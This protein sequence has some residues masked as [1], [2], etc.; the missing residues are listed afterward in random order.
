MITVTAPYNQ[1]NAPKGPTQQEGNIYFVEIDCAGV[2][3]YPGGQSAHKKEV[4]FRIASSGAWDASN[5]WSYAGIETKPGGTP[6][7]ARHI[8]VY[9]DGT[10]VF[11]TEPNGDAEAP[12]APSGL[13]ATAKTATSITLGWTASTDNVG[14]KAYDVYLGTTRVGT[15]ATTSYTVTGLTGGTSYAFTVRARDAAGNASP[16]SAP[17]TA[18]TQSSGPDPGPSPGVDSQAPSAPTGLAATAWTAT[19][20]TLGWSA[21]TDNVGVAGYDIYRGDQL[22]TSVPS[23][24]TSYTVTG[25]TASTTYAFTVKA[26]DAAGNRSAPTTISAATQA[27]VV[28]PDTQAPT[29]PGALTV[30]AKTATTVALSWSPS[31][32]DSG[33]V[34]YD[35]SVGSTVASS[36]SATSATVTGLTAGTSYTLSVRARDGAG[37]LSP[38]TSISVKTDDAAQSGGG[39]AATPPGLAGLGSL[40]ALVV[41]LRRRGSTPAPRG[42]EPPER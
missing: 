2:K 9:D 5:D 20:V 1:C 14:V 4:Q 41:A 39:C 30:T 25:L 24:S 23:T 13:T 35:V 8:V 28:G 11:G 7:K 19:S 29:A 10:R 18:S 34:A 17:V 37:N 12:T 3:L 36:T 40:I 22:V 6:V 26:R 21:S 16:P 38:A 42:G 33:T 31:T 15:S 32:D 27:E